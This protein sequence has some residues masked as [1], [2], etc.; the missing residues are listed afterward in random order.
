MK[1]K[2]EPKRH[3][4]LP[5]FYLSGFTDTG[6]SSKRL[7]AIDRQEAR[8]WQTNV[9]D[10]GVQSNL[11]G[12]GDV[13]PE[14]PAVW[15]KALAWIEDLVAP[16]LKEVRKSGE[17]PDG[18]EFEMLL[19]LVALMAVRVPAV[20]SR[21][22]ATFRTI[23]ID[24]IKAELESPEKWAAFESQFQETADNYNPAG[25]EKMKS[26][27]YSNDYD[28]RFTS[29]LFFQTMRI[30]V[31]ILLPILGNLQWTLFVCKTN[32]PDFVTS[33]RPVTLNGT[34]VNDGQGQMP[35]RK[36]PI[37][38]AFP[39]SKRMAMIGQWGSGTFSAQADRSIVAETNR[40]TIQFA[41]R[42]LY[43]PKAQI[44][45]TRSD[46]GTGNTTDLL[47]ELGAAK[48]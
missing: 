45:W 12:V 17:L 31:Q 25:Y 47:N 38:I 42:F 39:I 46:S 2:N 36:H 28:F 20:K 27:V 19:N 37:R 24:R 10:A 6:E 48:S 44:V 43:S 23:L 35:S 29:P 18:L 16:V 8:Q 41:A 13:H 9:T 33:D 11:H 21:A 14:D 30:G 5:R 32:A 7:W 4:F 22:E 15:E 1:K 34:L 3:H 26:F 40:G